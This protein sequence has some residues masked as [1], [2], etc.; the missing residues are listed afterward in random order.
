LPRQS[1]VPW[2]PGTSDYW[3]HFGDQI[4]APET[5]I[6]APALLEGVET[7][8]VRIRPSVVSLVTPVDLDIVT[9]HL[10]LPPQ[11]GFDLIIATNIFVYY[12][13]FEQMLAVANTQSMLRAGG[14]LLSNNSLPLMTASKMRSLDYLALQYS[15]LPGDGDVIAWYQRSPE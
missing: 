12:G 2:K 4:G 15:D 13:L 7:R 14:L 9:Q 3:R 10:D 5:P 6:R 11:E 8:A 1:Q